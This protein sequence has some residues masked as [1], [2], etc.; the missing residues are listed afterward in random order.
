VHAAIFTERLHNGHVL[1]GHTF[2]LRFVNEAEAAAAYD[3]A[4]RLLL[5]PGTSLNI[6]ASDADDGPCALMHTAILLNQALGP[7][8]TP[9]HV[10]ALARG[11]GVPSELAEGVLAGQKPRRQ[12]DARTILASQ[13]RQQ[14]VWL[15]R[16]GAQHL[17]QQQLLQPP[18]L[19][20]GL[21]HQQRG[22]RRQN[23]MQ[24][25]LEDVGDK[26]SEHEG[27]ESSRGQA[28]LQ[29]LH[30]NQARS[31]PRLDG[32]TGK[33]GQPAKRPRRHPADSKAS[34]T[35][36]TLH[37]RRD[38][39]AS[40]MGSGDT[41]APPRG[42]SHTNHPVPS[43]FLQPQQHQ[44]IQSCSSG[45]TPAPQHFE[46][47]PDAVTSRRPDTGV[48]GTA[49][50]SVDGVLDKLM[51]HAAT[52]WESDQPGPITHQQPRPGLLAQLRRTV[53]PDLILSVASDGRGLP[54]NPTALCI[55][56]TPS[57]AATASSAL[58]PPPRLTSAVSPSSA[59]G[60]ADPPADFWSDTLPVA[61]ARLRR[62][63]AAIS[64]AMTHLEELLLYSPG[65]LLAGLQGASPT[66]DTG[67]DTAPG[68]REAAQLHA[69]ALAA[70]HA[71]VNQR[72]VLDRMR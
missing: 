21:Q 68:G 22:G 28:P 31:P 44:A 62:P 35:P 24:R 13:R 27:E 34:S 54:S 67:H 40:T 64:A 53:T 18:L 65:A 26:A 72:A 71:F 6:S 12:L 20:P 8:S 52:V 39:T 1:T 56:P 58:A 46:P 57:P 45:L 5:G 25:Q 70:V 60:S 43:F 32:H 41:A 3:R 47:K 4:A 69:D 17:N 50:D 2:P 51:H 66:L 37:I 14:L 7:A 59:R 61:D 55:V 42:S 10:Q 9:P 16:Q 19:P 63:R 36:W 49:Q 38:N 29:L 15:Q 30:A 23:E 33:E 48:R 11:E